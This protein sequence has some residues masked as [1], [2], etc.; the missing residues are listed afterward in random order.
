LNRTN[1]RLINVT[2]SGD[3]TFK[4]NVSSSFSTRDFRT[5]TV[6][7]HS[8]ETKVDPDEWDELFELHSI[9][10][11]AGP[12][13]RVTF[14]NRGA[15]TSISEGKEII[16]NEVYHRQRSTEPEDSEFELSE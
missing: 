16:L 11:K 9:V 7:L 1:D 4:F 3:R 13:E 8:F 6:Q 2:G 12:Y 10:I 15:F 14:R 5:A